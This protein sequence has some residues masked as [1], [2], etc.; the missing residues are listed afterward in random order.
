MAWNGEL[1]FLLIENEK[2]LEGGHAR[3]VLHSKRGK[4]KERSLSVRTL[5]PGS[6]KNHCLSL[7]MM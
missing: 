6:P 3:V 5:T 4:Q 7:D 1:P 2:T